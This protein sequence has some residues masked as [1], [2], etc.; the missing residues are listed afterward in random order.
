M[1]WKDTLE[2]RLPALGHR[3]WIVVADAAYPKHCAP[4]METVYTGGKL[5]DVLK[6]VLEALEG[7]AHVR[8]V[9]WL[10]AELAFVDEADAPGADEL[11]RG[12]E[13]KLAGLEVRRVPH[14]EIIEKLDAAARSFDVLLLKTD[15]T[16][17]YTSVFLELGCGYWSAEQEERMRRAIA[18]RS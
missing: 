14:E 15:L 3:N 7:A 16:I 11:R 5:L 12:L 17:P 10:D 13:E 4:G 1:S 8:P 2:R 6:K 9:A 18:D